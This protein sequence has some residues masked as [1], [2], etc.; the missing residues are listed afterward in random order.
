MIHD[1][2]MLR[3]KFCLVQ[4]LELFV[5]VSWTKNFSLEPSLLGG[6]QAGSWRKPPN[7]IF[8]PFLQLPPLRAKYPSLFHRSHLQ[9]T[10]GNTIFAVEG[11]PCES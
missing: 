6:R 1:G 11:G 10:G 8:P 7:F 5:F 3:M 2:L 9:R 4:V